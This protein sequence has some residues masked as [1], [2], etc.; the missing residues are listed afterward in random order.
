MKTYYYTSQTTHY[1]PYLSH[2]GVK[3]MKWGVRRYQ[4]EDGSLTSKGEKRKAKLAGKYQRLSLKV[5]RAQSENVGRLQE[6]ALTTVNTKAFFGKYKPGTNI[7]DEYNRE[8][9]KNYLKLTESNRY[10]KKSQR[11]VEKYGAK[12][13]SVLAENNEHSMNVLRDYVDRKIEY[14]DVESA[15]KQADRAR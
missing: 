7:A 5:Q 13:I 12:N 6:E 4:N 3:G 2:H 9:S 10:Y 15:M 8:F 11:M 14:N 1:E